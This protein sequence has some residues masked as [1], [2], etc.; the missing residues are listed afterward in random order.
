M[1]FRF[2]DLRK[3]IGWRLHASSLGGLPSPVKAVCPEIFPEMFGPNS[4]GFQTPLNHPTGRVTG[5]NLVRPFL[6]SEPKGAGASS[7]VFQFFATELSQS[8]SFTHRLKM[9]NSSAAC[10]HRCCGGR[11]RAACVFTGHSGPVRG[12]IV[13]SGGATPSPH[14]DE[15]SQL[16]DVRPNSPPPEC[17][18]QLA[19]PRVAP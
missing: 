17:C 3:F 10:F 2:D 7:F 6:V 18:P 15:T 13:M 4:A 16:R 12:T 19:V 9:R 14:N 5:K 8:K 11:S 1:N